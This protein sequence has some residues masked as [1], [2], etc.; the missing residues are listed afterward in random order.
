MGG[1]MGGGMGAMGGGMG[2][3]GGGMG[4]MGA[5]G[6]AGAMGGMGTGAAGMMPGMMPGML[7]A[8]GISSGS[9]LSALLDDNLKGSGA[10]VSSAEEFE[11]EYLLAGIKPEY[12]DMA[13]G[14]ETY[15]T[16][17]PSFKNNLCHEDLGGSERLRSPCPMYLQCY[18]CL[19][20]NPLYC[21]DHDDNSHH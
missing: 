8:A 16:T 9:G 11:F 5:M 15:L 20:I 6:G 2:G 3:M 18:Y 7:G 17:C 13:A 4:G 12:A 19:R 14:F 1:G 21:L 10:I